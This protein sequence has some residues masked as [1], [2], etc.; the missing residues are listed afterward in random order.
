VPYFCVE[1]VFSPP[2][3]REQFAEAGKAL[4]PCIQERDIKH[5]ASHMA[6]D[7]SR[8]VCVYEAAD[9]ERVREANRT[10]GAPFER[11]WATDIYK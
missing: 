10:A 5:V 9:A 7:G 6:V 4:A 3:T 11:V 2:I 1:R 8:S